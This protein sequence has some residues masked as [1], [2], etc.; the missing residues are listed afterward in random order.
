M[1][2][3]MFAV[4]AIALAGV[5]LARQERGRGMSIAALVLGVIGLLGAIGSQV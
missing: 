2:M 4:A 3:V 5:G 1:G